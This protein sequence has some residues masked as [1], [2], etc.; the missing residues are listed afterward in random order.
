MA[1]AGPPAA[2]GDRALGGRGARDADRRLI[3]VRVTHLEH[4]RFGDHASSSSSISGKSPGSTPRVRGSM[5]APIAALV[6]RRPVTLILKTEPLKVLV[7]HARLTH[8]RAIGAGGGNRMVTADRATRTKL[9]APLRR[10]MR[11]TRPTRS[12]MNVPSRRRP[13]AGRSWPRAKLAERFGG[14]C[15]P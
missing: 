7:K 11:H 4:A 6:G 13:W 12:S 15:H 8:A 2:P 14:I 1:I 3:G 10:P 5:L 9:F